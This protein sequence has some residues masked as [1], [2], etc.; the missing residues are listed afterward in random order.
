VISDF[1]QIH[2]QSEANQK[3]RSFADHLTYQAE[4]IYPEGWLETRYVMP[5]AVQIMTIHQAKASSGQLSLCP[6]SCAAAFLHRAQAA[7]SPG[8]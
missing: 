2:L 6:V 8:A 7:C 4:S 5:N 1:E 3:Y